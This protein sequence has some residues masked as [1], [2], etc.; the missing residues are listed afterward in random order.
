MSENAHA[1]IP[2]V[3]KF[4]SSKLGGLPNMLLISGAVGLV[5]TAIGGFIDKQQFAYTYLFAFAVFFT[6]IMGAAFWLCLHHATDSE[7]SVVI[8]RQIENIASLFPYLAIF[9]L[10]A[11]LCANI[12]WKWWGLPDG[13]DPLLDVKRPYLSEWFFLLRLVLYF[14][15]V[16][17]V[18]L[19]LRGHSVKQD[20][21]GKGAHSYSMR[22][23]GVGGIPAVALTITFGGFDW[24]MGLDYHWFSTMWGVYLFAGAA[25]SSMALIVLVI[26]ALKKRGYLSIVN[27]EHYHIMGKF[28]L[29]FTIF[30]AYVGFSQYMLIWYANIPE[31]NIYFIIRNQ[32]NWVWL[33]T[34]LVFFRF[35]VALPILL[36]QWVKKNPNYL[37]FVAYGM[38]AMQV[39]DIFIIVI[40]A[41]RKTGFGLVDVVYALCPLVGIGGI[42]AWLFLRKLSDSALFPTRDPRLALS[43][44]LHN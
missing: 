28:M 5:L 19:S 17:L 6:L 38:I 25:G 12:L 24:L 10:P 40:P 35:F 4:D 22:K 31:E 42:L 1:N 18:V 2:E 8:R 20:S 27:N 29:A 23:F 3:E 7:W 9:F 26:N 43:I 36:T 13:V 30:W 33:T 44:N 37:A 15:I 41:L 14:G 21:D 32:G 39:L 16:S 11:L 34:I